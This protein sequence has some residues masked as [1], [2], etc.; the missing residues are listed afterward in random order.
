L[1][2]KWARGILT[3]YN[4]NAVGDVIGV[5]YSD[6]TTSNVT[7]TLDR[8][9]RRTTIIDAGGTHNFIYNDANLPLSETNSGGLLAGL[10]LT[11]TYDS[12]L[13][14]AQIN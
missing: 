10:S 2:R 7:Y 12:Q 5:T 6:N 8:L 4:T 3:T 9:G 11:N 14:G 1:N 13:V